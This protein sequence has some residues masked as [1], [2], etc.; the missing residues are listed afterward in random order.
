VVFA[1]ALQRAVVRA[2][3]ALSV[4]ITTSC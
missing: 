4:L 1:K 3:P 2:T